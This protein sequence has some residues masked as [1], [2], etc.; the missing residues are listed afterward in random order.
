MDRAAGKRT[1]AGSDADAIPVVVSGLYG[2]AEGQL[3]GAAAGRE[4]GL[5]R[6]VADGQREHWLSRDVDC[7][8]EVH[9]HLDGLAKAVGAPGWQRSNRHAFDRQSGIAADYVAAIGPQSSEGAQCVDTTSPLDRAAGKRTGAGSDAD[10]VVVVVA[11]LHEV[12]E[13]QRLRA[14]A[15]RVGCLSGP[16]ADGEGQ[17]YF[18]RYVDLLAER[19]LDLDCI[20]RSIGALSRRRGYSRFEDGRHCWGAAA[21]AIHLRIALGRRRVR[22]PH[23]LVVAGID[24]RAAGQSVRL[25]AQ[26][27]VIEVLGL[28]GVVEDQRVSAAAGGKRRLAHGGADGERHGGLRPG[29]VDDFS[30]YDLDLNRFSGP[31]CIAIPRLVDNLD[32]VDAWRNAILLGVYELI[33]LRVD[34]GYASRLVHPV[35]ASAILHEAADQCVAADADAVVVIVALA[36]D[37]AEPQRVGAAAIDVLGVGRPSADAEHE[38]QLLS[39]LGYERGFRELHLDLDD[40]AEAVAAARRPAGNPRGP[41][42][43]RHGIDN[44]AVRPDGPVVSVCQ[45]AIGIFYARPHKGRVAWRDADAVI[46]LV[47]FLHD[48][49][50]DQRVRA[51]AFRE[52]GAAGMFANGEDQPQLFVFVVGRFGDEHGLVEPDLHLHHVALGEVACVA[53]RRGVELDSDHRGRLRAPVYLVVCLLGERLDAALPCVVLPVVA[54]AVLYSAASQGVW[55]NADAIGVRIVRLHLVAKYERPRAAASGVRRLARV[56]ADGQLETWI[57]GGVDVFVPCDANF[58]GL[59]E[60]IGV[61]VERRA[62]DRHVAGRGRHGVD[63]MVGVVIDAREHPRGWVACGVLDSAAHKGIGSDA[64]AILVL[65][66]GDHDVAKR[67]HRRTGVHESGSAA[68]VG[69]AGRYVPVAEGEKKHR[70]AAHRN[71]LAE[72]HF[73]LDGVASHVGVVRASSGSEGHGACGGRSIYLMAFLDSEG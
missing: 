7:C 71:R 17:C 43:Q 58:D 45:R 56:G 26:A 22:I 23:C 12:A 42:Q 24:D 51:A 57:V 62:G 50:E 46:V 68:G 18:A 10:A 34:G 67:Q 15:A 55:P 28:D 25:N 8:G 33:L 64:H 1:G 27:V 31:E 44:V 59:A 48:V 14:T 63:E 38:R 21:A 52:D 29:H 39:G 5:P 69:L 13:R 72:R 65:V 60:S 30:E 20:A 40:L 54:G 6:L 16:R 4:D 32:L 2:V 37:V 73:Q 53:C 9:R 41:G 3:A 35:V 19:D 61:A 70:A 49:A 36:H 47:A 66:A 11:F